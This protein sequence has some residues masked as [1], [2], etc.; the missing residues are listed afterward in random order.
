MKIAP[1]RNDRHRR[2]LERHFTLNWEFPDDRP[3]VVR[4]FKARFGWVARAVL[5]P[6]GAPFP[7]A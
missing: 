3:R 4:I 7:Y 1:P 6:K 5:L 2:Q